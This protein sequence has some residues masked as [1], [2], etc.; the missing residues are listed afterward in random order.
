MD[1]RQSAQGQPTC[2]NFAKIVGCPRLPSHVGSAKIQAVPL[3]GGL[4]PPPLRGSTLLNPVSAHSP[5]VA[6]ASFLPASPAGAHFVIAGIGCR[7]LVVFSGAVFDFSS[8]VLQ[9]GGPLF[10]AFCNR[11]PLPFRLK[12]LA[13]ILLTPFPRAHCSRPHGSRRRHGA[14]RPLKNHCGV[15]KA[16][17]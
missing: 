7:T 14:R 15:I 3:W 2:K 17:D 6:C 10:D 4:T 9:G 1:V 5:D 16:C 8:V 11:G 12:N 13:I